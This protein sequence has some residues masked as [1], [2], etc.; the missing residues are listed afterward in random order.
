METKNIN[1]MDKKEFEVYTKKIVD[2]LGDD[3]SDFFTVIRDTF[4]YFTVIDK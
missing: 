1:S 4:E 3:T 2:A